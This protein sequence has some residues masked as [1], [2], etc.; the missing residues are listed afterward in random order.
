M[1][2]SSN[3]ERRPW[4][5]YEV[6]KKGDGF[7]V[8][9]ITVTKGEMISLQYHNHRDEQWFIVSGSG[10]MTLGEERFPIGEN[11]TV[12]IP[13]KVIHRIEGI[14]DITFVEVQKGDLLEESDIVRLDDKYNRVKLSESKKE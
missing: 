7:V 2:E 6:L 3:F 12:S 14:S 9:T 8:K 11:E 10:I 1:E 13:K 4:G 5:S